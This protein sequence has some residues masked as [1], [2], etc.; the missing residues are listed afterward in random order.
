[1]AIIHNCSAVLGLGGDLNAYWLQLRSGR[2]V[3]LREVPDTLKAAL[4]RG[5]NLGLIVLAWS[6]RNHRPEIY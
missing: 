6:I 5:K 1:M 4:E 2:A 3:E